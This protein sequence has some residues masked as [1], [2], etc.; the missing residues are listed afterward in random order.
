MRPG[1][2]EADRRC[3]SVRPSKRGPRSLLLLLPAIDYRPRRSPVKR[4]MS[5]FSAVR[6]NERRRARSEVIP[7]CEGLESCFGRLTTLPCRFQ[8]RSAPR[9]C[10]CAQ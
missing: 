7:R 1:H 8:Q 10:A 4:S 5:Y 9:A 2:E 6:P 3:P